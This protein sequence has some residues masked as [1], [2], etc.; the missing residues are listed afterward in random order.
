MKNVF[1]QVSFGGGGFGPLIGNPV[2]LRTTAM[3]QPPAWSAPMTPPQEWP[4][5]P[6]AGPTG[7]LYTDKKKKRRR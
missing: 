2:P 4:F 1:G 3:G 7:G 5:F 6:F